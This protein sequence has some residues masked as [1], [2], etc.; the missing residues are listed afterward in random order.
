LP[1]LSLIDGVKFITN[2]RGI[3]DA[4]LRKVRLLLPDYVMNMLSIFSVAWWFIQSTDPDWLVGGFD[5][6]S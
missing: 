5:R 1:I 3:L 2:A 4:G 6:F